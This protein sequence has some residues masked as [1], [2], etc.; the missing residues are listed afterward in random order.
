MKKTAKKTDWKTFP[1]DT[2]KKIDID[3]HFSQTQ[4]EKVSKGFIPKQ[5]E[6]K[7][8]IYF[9]DGWL[10]LHRSWT[11]I[12]IYNAQVIEGENDYF[13]NEFCVERNPEKHRT[14]NDDQ[15]IEDFSFLIARALLGLDVNSTYSSRNIFS[16]AD[17]MRGWNTFGNL[18]FTNKGIDYT[19]QIRSAL[20][21]VAVGD[22]L[23]VPAEFTDRN[24]L[25]DNP[26]TGMTGYGMH[27]QPPG[28]WSDDSSL[29]F[30]L[31]ETLT[32]EYNLNAIAESFVKWY[33]DNYWTAR[34]SVFDIGNGT[35]DA[36][37]NLERGIQPELA[38]RRDERSN[39]NGSLMRILP[40]V[41]Y[42]LDKPDL[43]GYEL[44]KKISSI[45]HGHIHSIIACFYYLEFARLIIQN[46][47]K[48]AIYAELQKLFLD[49][50]KKLTLTSKQ[51]SVFR[52]LLNGNIYELEEKDIFS[53]GYVIHT[54][55]ASIWCLMTTD[56][57]KDAVLKA[58][59]L[60]DDTDT[61][62]AITG[63]L[64]GLYYGYNSIPGEWIKNIA[65]KADIEDLVE[66]FTDNLNEPFDQLSLH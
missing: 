7:W 36:I 60:G 10:H 43:E 11:G 17:T 19:E 42:I 38:G 41:F 30:C 22:A 58:V 46:L 29:T 13:I 52:R 63:G 55:E 23:G 16:E 47:E 66:R 54:L 37:M 18:L 34:G 64:A 6:D 40:L 50:F 15:D 12:E 4:F 26:I 31:A 3:L 45:T 56:N 65:R 48:T 53:S 1:I 32:H 57:F 62:G 49:Y 5:M 2:P 9:K 44:T 25:K 33:R 24:Q 28:T 59:N 21:G 27:M 35:K 20:F 14:D 39:G 51:V 61:V 8:F